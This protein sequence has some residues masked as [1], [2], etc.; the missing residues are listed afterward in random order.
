M[1][2]PLQPRHVPFYDDDLVAVQQPDGAIFVVFTRVCDALGLKRWSQARRVQAHAVL[3]TGLITLTI[4]TEGGPQEAQCLRLDLLPL[5]LSGIQVSRVKPELQQHLLRYQTEAAGV[6]WQ[7][8][9]PQILVES[10]HAR[11]PADS[12]AIVQ[13]Q[14]IAE[15]AHAIGRMAEQQIELQRQ[16]Q[17]LDSRMDSAARII[18]RVQG[19][20][21]DVFGD[22]ATVQVRLGVLEGQLQ[23]AGVV[24]AAQAAEISLRVKA[25]GE[26]LTTRDPSKNHYQGIFG[27][28]YRRFG[29]SSYKLIR[30]DQYPAVLQFLE[31]WRASVGG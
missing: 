11:G 3:Q 15:M 19:Q 12:S 24:T 31:D 16:H 22:L 25:L 5:W 26:G 4:Q 10:D 27:E 21:E 8:F 13:L 17:V 7:A 18:K 9:G 14:Q 29:V 6:L 20:V 23:P 28:L 30:Q 1:T 2:A